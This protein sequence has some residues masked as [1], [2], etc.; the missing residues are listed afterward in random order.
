MNTRAT[1]DAYLIFAG[2]MQS[3]EAKEQT[4]RYRRW[5]R[6][7]A[8]QRVWIASVCRYGRISATAAMRLLNDT[9]Y[10]D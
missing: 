10:H 2:Y 6:E 9:M 4:K 3:R 8:Q 7:H 1:H 5:R